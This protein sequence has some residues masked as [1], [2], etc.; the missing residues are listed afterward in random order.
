MFAHVNWLAV[1]GAAIVAFAIGAV[2][3]SAL[4]SR[5]WRELVGV[6]A[7]TGAPSTGMMMTPLLVNFVLTL[8]SATSVAVIVTAFPADAGIA[9]FVGLLI[10]AATVL[11]VKLNDV[12]FAHRPVGLF[13]IDGGLQLITLVVMAVIVSV[14]RA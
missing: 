1:L 13:Y 8:V 12:A 2:W 7:T 10:W 4:F 9:A 6:P 3:Y 14:F 5:Q 11:A